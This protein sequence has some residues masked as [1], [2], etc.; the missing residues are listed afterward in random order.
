[1]IFW[2]VCNQRSIQLYPGDE[3]LEAFIHQIGENFRLRTLP[4]VQTS[5]IILSSSL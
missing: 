4:L 1:M 5:G 2:L 3:P